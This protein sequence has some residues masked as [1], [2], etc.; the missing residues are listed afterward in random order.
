M[1]DSHI[2][3][4]SENSIR[5]LSPSGQQYYCVLRENR[6]SGAG[7]VGMLEGDEI[8]LKPDQ[9]KESIFLREEE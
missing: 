7:W 9:S 3:R 1:F 4:V 5:F 2:I 8:D 6:I